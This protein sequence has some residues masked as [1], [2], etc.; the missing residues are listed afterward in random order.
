MSVINER[1]KEI[2]RRRHRSKKVAKLKAKYAKA[3][4]SEQQEIVRKIRA[5]TPG[6]ESIVAG[7]ESR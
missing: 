1:H 3:N 5:L 6:A 4:P 7:L 2:N